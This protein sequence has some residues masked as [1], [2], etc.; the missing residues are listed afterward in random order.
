MNA[1]E[2][3]CP[4]VSVVIPNFNREAELQR[5]VDSVLA[6]DYTPLEVVVVDDASTRP[7][8]LNLPPEKRE[9][10]RWVQLEV[11]GGGATAR[12]AG[13]D[14]ARGELVAFLDSDDVWT[15]D[16]LARQVA[17]YIADGRPREAVYYSQVVLDRGD[18][19]LV[20][21]QRA[22]APGEGVGDYLF[23][24]RGNLIHTSTLLM[25]RAL[26]A[27]VRFTDGLRIHQDVDF[28]LRLQRDGA[29]FRFLAVPLSRWHAEARADRMSHR[30]KFLLSLDWLAASGELMPWATRQKFAAQ[31]ASRMPAQVWHSPGTVARALWRCRS[32][33]YISTAYMLRLISQIILPQRWSDGLARAVKPRRVAAGE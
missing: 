8:K 11:N 13:I 26:A 29:G 16:K 12:N 21:P 6:Q 15:T 28:C 10:L 30:P 25:S 19:E 17:A 14:A 5:A 3:T 27:R 22:L 20:L 2:N 4:L 32:D 33:G 23:P 7:V 9:L 24:W 1:G 18:E 31:L